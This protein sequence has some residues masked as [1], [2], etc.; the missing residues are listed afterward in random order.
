MLKSMPAKA[1]ADKDGMPDEWE[2]ANGLNPADS[3]D[4]KGNKLHNHYTNIEFYIN[5]LV[6]KSF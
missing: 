5:S 1:D 4:V 3:T 2:Q 6:P